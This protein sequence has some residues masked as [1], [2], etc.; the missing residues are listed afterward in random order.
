M[1][2]VAQ[3]LKQTQKTARKRTKVP[4][5]AAGKEGRTVLDPDGEALYLPRLFPASTSAKLLKDLQVRQAALL[6]RSAGCVIELYK[7]RPS[8]THWSLSA[9]ASLGPY[10]C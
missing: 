7:H 4:A 6:R 9:E 8:F 3:T 2:S 5:P 1:K 10:P